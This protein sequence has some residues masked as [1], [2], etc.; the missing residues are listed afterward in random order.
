MIIFFGILA[1]ILMLLSI[2]EK[3]TANKHVYMIGFAV[4]LAATL[5]AKYLQ[6]VG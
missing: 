1:V 6:L 3:V 4:S 5:L 2:S